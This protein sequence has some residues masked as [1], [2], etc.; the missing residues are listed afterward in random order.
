MKKLPNP[1]D[2]AFN[3][4][5]D[6][7]QTR[8]IKESQGD[9]LKLIDLDQKRYTMFDFLSL[10]SKS[11]WGWKGDGEPITKAT[12]DPFKLCLTR[13]AAYAICGIVWCEEKS[14]RSIEH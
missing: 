12:I 13:V 5:S 8:A 7:I 9:Y 11:L 6:I 4:I 14:K 10:I 2:D 1:Y 3:N